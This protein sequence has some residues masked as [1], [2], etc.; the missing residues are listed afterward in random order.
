MYITIDIGGTKTLLAAWT[1]DGQVTERIKFPTPKDYKDLLS[2]I[3]A[4]VAKLSTKEWD[5]GVIGISGH[6]NREDGIIY[7]LG[8]LP[9]RN[10]HIRDDISKILG[11]VHLL[12]E[13]DARLAGLAEAIL[14]KDKYQRVLYLTVSTG[15]GGALLENGQIVTALQDT[16][17]GKMPLMFEGKLTHWEDFAGGRGV[18]NTY[19]KKAFEL[20]DP[21]DW[22]NI[23]LRI[24]YGLGAVCAVLQPEVVVFGGGVGQFVD[25]FGGA[26]ADYLKKNI[27]PVVGPPPKALLAAQHKE[28]GVIYG[29]YE[30]AKAAHGMARQ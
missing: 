7:A 23:G 19:G 13:N 26:I 28:D 30:L 17:M 6:I 25:K 29:S 24:A 22:E 21:K 15:I 1:N 3:A 27:H 9:W 14:L 11:G 2:E 18:V 10:E 8:N 12:M 4:N 20:S 16:E 5:L